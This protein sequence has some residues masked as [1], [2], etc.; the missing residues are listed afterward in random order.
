MW[1]ASHF[2]TPLFEYCVPQEL[3]AEISDPKGFGNALAAEL[4]QL[5]A[6]VLSAGVARKPAVA[7]YLRL[8]LDRLSKH[9][10]VISYSEQRQERLE[11]T[12]EFVSRYATLRLS[13]AGPAMFADSIAGS[14]YPI[15]TQWEQTAELQQLPHRRSLASVYWYHSGAALSFLLDGLDVDRWRDH[16]RQGSNLDELLALSVFAHDYLEWH[17]KRPERQ[18]LCRAP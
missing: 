5:S 1:Q 15:V 9:P 4:T 2:V 16:V 17:A 6:A 13:T 7:E 12:A 8:R 10:P 11:G 3:P 18:T 14:L